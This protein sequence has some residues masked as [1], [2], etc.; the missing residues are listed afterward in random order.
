M[1]KG[2]NTKAP[3]GGTGLYPHL[4]GQLLL[5]QRRCKTRPVHDRLLRRRHL[6][7][8]RIV[9][10]TVQRRKS[11]SRPLEGL[12]TIAFPEATSLQASTIVPP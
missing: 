11:L 12:L 1:R 8:I 7:K 3:E 2:R 9:I 4:L 6:N 5:R 10:A